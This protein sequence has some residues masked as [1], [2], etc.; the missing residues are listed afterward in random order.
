MGNVDL[1][2][3]RMAVDMLPSTYSLTVDAVLSFGNLTNVVGNVM[4]MVTHFLTLW[5]QTPSDY[6][7]LIAASIR[8]DWAARY[9]PIISRLGEHQLYTGF[10]VIRPEGKLVICHRNCG[11]EHL[12]WRV[13]NSFVKVICRSCQSECIIEK[14]HV[15][16]R[17]ILGSRSLVRVNFPQEQARTT[18]I[19]HGPNEPN[20]SEI[21]PALPA[22]AAA[23]LHPEQPAPIP[24]IGPS[25]R[26]QVANSVPE[27]PDTIVLDRASSTGTTPPPSPSPSAS[28]A[29]TD[30]RPPSPHPA[31]MK[32]SRSS[33]ADA[34]VEPVQQT[35]WKIRVPPRPS[36]QPRPSAQPRPSTRPRPSA[37]PSRP[38][39]STSRSARRSQP[40][41]EAPQIERAQSA[42]EVEMR[43][44][45]TR[46]E[47]IPPFEVNTAS[48]GKRRRED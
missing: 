10:S 36:N 24:R 15:D 29:P 20:N 9:L 43:D 44:A 31:P 45:P 30:S 33:S 3:T 21:P 8:S 40:R 39:R 4:H 38:L 37:R 6:D 46:L 34:L 35:K 14:T 7:T 16:V 2:Y 28:P 32:S 41:L 25:E 22:V 48:L 11:K 47:D 27:T 1:L 17:T 19:F 26:A 13:R 42:P 18:W 12:A 5:A 23:T